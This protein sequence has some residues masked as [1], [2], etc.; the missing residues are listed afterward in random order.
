MNLQQRK[1]LTHDLTNIVAAL[2]TVSNRLRPNVD[3]RIIAIMDDTLSKLKKMNAEID[4]TVRESSGGF[5]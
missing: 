2:T 5:E 4:T 1:K 3:E